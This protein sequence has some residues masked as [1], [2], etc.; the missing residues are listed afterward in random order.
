[1]LPTAIAVRT[2]RRNMRRS[3]RA[4]TAHLKAMAPSGR[5]IRKGAVSCVLG[6]RDADKS[7]PA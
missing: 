3:P 7:N 1:M 4:Q 2:D 5:G 6:L